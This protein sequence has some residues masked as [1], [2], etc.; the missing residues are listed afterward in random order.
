[1]NTWSYFI[2]SFR[3]LFEAIWS[4]FKSYRYYPSSNSLTSNQKNYALYV[5]MQF[6]A[7]SF[8]PLKPL[9]TLFCNGH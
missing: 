7:L 6:A 4:V 5:F 3:F 2:H 1:M 8:F 9:H